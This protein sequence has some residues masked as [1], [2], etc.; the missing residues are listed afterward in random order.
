MRKSLSEIFSRRAI[1]FAAMLLTNPH[2]TNFLSGRLYRG[3]L[4]QNP[5]RENSATKHH[6]HSIED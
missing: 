5:A 6:Q 2:V 3:E 4:F 1:Q